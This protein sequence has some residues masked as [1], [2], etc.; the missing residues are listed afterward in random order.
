MNI[1]RSACCLSVALLLTGP[2]LQATPILPG[3]SVVPEQFE[4][5]GESANILGETEGSFSFSTNSGFSLSG[6]Y[7]QGVLVDPW[8]TYCADCLTFFYRVSVS[9]NS[10]LPL[11]VLGGGGFEGFETSVAWVFPEDEE[12]DTNVGMDPLNAVRSADGN[13]VIFN[14][15]LPGVF[16]N[17]VSPGLDTAYL[18][19]QT[20]AIAFD[21]SGVFGVASGRSVDDTVLGLIQ[22]MYAPAVTTVPEPASLAL[23]AAGVVGL[24]MMRRRRLNPAV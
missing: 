5:P 19:I 12:D 11:L 17:V 22:G 10:Q 15:L 18:V 7:E 6:E 14:F 3:Q 2:A 23:L 16:T 21:Q 20:N 24:F 8:G 13:N 4:N 1:F 9:P